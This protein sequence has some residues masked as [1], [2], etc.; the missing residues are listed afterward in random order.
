MYMLDLMQPISAYVD[1]CKRCSEAEFALK[2]DYP[3]LVHSSLTQRK[4][5][6]VQN[7]MQETEDQLLVEP[8]NTPTKHQSFNPESLYTVYEVKTRPGSSVASIGRGSLCD[9]QIN[10]SSISRTHAH[11]E[12]QESTYLLCDDNSSSGTSVNGKQIPPG[13]SVVL[14]PGDR[15]GLGYL[16]LVFL[17]PVFFHRF[18]SGLFAE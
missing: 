4:L 13:D 17:V 15:I 3:F 11:I 9:V 8:R 12:F 10:D 14:T 5:Q 7:A 16:N 6:P 1:V 18:V 2:Y